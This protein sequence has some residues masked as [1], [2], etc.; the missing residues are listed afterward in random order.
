MDEIKNDDIPGG[1]ILRVNMLGRLEVINS[2]GVLN[3]DNIRSEMV[4][5]LFSYFL[6]H[7]DKM[8]SVLELSD[9]LWPDDR[10]ENPTGALKNLIYRLRNIVK[11]TLGN[12]DFILTG[13]GTY[14]WNKNIKVELDVEQFEQY[15]YEAKISNRTDDENVKLYSEAVRLYKGQFLPKMSSDHWVIPLVTYYHSLYLRTV[16]DL[17]S[18]LEK[19]GRY[20]EVLGICTQAIDIDPLDEKLHYYF[21]KA[22]IGQGKQNLAIEHYTAATTLLYE[23]LGVKPTKQLWDIYR[24][25]VK[26]KNKQEMDVN[27]IQKDL[28]EAAKP[29]GIFLCEYGTFKEIYRLEARRA[30][31]LGMSVYLALMTMIPSSRIPEE[32]NTFLKVTNDAMVKMQQVLNR[33]M[34]IGDVVA[35]Y[36]GSQYVVLLPTC[37]FETASMV[38]KRVLDEFYNITK[39]KTVRVEYSLSELSLTDI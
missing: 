11:N 1:K 39:Q 27:V 5:R 34:R 22:L 19:K 28:Q 29:S 26:E 23:N 10:S 8:I 24:E 21:I 6:C 2:I 32:S 13:R 14:F 9:V 38:L 4:T 17:A 18:L 25:I 30:G 15:V 33:K 12:S 31:R 16:K 35:K 20:E 36:S 7:R 3:D 37:T